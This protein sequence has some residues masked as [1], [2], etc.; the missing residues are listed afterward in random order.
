M[1]GLIEKVQRAVHRLRSSGRQAASCAYTVIDADRAGRYGGYGWCGADVAAEQDAAYQ[2]LLEQMQRGEPRRD[3]VVAAEAVRATGLHNPAILEVGCGSGY[4][5]QALA[6]LLGRPVNYTGLDQSQA[7]IDL[8]QQ[9]YCAHR[10]VQGDATDLPFDHNA[11]DI[12]L[13]GV[14][15]MHICRYQLAITE[16]ARVARKWCIYHTVPVLVHRPTTFLLKKAYGQPTVE[17]IFNESELLDLWCAAGL[18]LVS[19]QQSIAYDLQAVL[20]EPTV[21]KTYLCQHTSAHQ[22]ETSLP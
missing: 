4:Y 22:D 18:E 10:F 7:M 20:G 5:A 15:L 3:F 2:Q 14:S 12:V 9:R 11:F 21:T 16:A 6:H 17:V 8:A 13:N 19:Q 1:N